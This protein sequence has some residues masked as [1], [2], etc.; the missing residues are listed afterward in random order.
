MSLKACARLLKSAS[1]NFPGRV[2][3]DMPSNYPWWN[4]KS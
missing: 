4:D 3:T 1:P 2:S